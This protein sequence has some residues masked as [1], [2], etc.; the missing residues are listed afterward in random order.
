MTR[1]YVYII[2]AVLAG[3]SIAT[4]FYKWQVLGFPVSG[5]QEQ[6]VRTIETSIRFDAA[7]RAATGY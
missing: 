1:R 6:P 2:A 5:D 7:V 3:I 4:F